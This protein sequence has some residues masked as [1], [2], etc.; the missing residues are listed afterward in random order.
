MELNDLLTKEAHEEGAELN[1]KDPIT[2]DPTDFFIMVAGLDSELAQKASIRMRHKAVEALTNKKPITEED[3]IQTE[4]D[5]LTASTIGWRGLQSEGKEKK[6]T[7]KACADL[8]AR[9]PWLRNQVDIFQRT[10]ANFT[11]G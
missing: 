6:F 3:E 9:S 1:I 2:G 7:S 10:R 11:K 4:I 8:Y 5:R